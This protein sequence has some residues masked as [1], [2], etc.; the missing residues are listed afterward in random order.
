[1]LFYIPKEPLAIL[2]L[3]ICPGVLAKAHCASMSVK[4][5]QIDA[6]DS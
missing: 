4:V 1:M 5:P 2:S 3:E 6:H